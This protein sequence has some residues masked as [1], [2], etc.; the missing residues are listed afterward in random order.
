MCE[1]S[2]GGNVHNP[3]KALTGTHEIPLNGVRVAF[4]AGHVLI[5]SSKHVKYVRKPQVKHVSA[6]S[7]GAQL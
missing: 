1:G 3:E 7:H 5:K 2:S 4:R 6:L